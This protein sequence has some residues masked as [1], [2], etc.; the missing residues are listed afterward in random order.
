MYGNSALVSLAPVKRRSAV[1]DDVTALT[2][3]GFVTVGGCLLTG[4]PRSH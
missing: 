3:I 1:A 2:R 4:L